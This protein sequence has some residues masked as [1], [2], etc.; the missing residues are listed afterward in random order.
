MKHI[1]N[2]YY[3]I[4]KKI[5]R[6]QVE[7]AFKHFKTADDNKTIKVNSTDIANIYTKNIM[8][9]I[10]NRK[11]V[12][13]YYAYKDGILKTILPYAELDIEAFRDEGKIEINKNLLILN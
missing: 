6:H 10:S 2:I 11:Y 12:P 5:Y 3:W 8:W 1:K 4:K 13:Y 7:Q 9:V